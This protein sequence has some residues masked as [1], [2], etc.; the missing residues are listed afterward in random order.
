MA[1]A[2][3]KAKL[4]YSGT[5]VN[6]TQNNVVGKTSDQTVHPNAQ[7]NPRYQILV[8][9]NY[10]LYLA[11]FLLPKDL[12]LINTYIFHLELLHTP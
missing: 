11:S 3:L 7:A 2:Y 10:F 8:I 12:D 1:C 4:F 5:L 6:P 9:C